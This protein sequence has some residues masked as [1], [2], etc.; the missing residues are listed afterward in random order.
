MD[1]IIEIKGLT[2]YYGSLF[3]K[4]K[5]PSLYDL[6]L[7]IPDGAIFGFLGPNGAGK[8]T[9]IKI[10]MNLIKQSSGEALI[11]GYPPDNVEVKRLIGFLPMLLLSVRI[12]QQPSSL[13]SAPNCSEYRLISAKRE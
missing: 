4:K 12:F 8:T 13:T 9:T 11:L 1:N 10:L 2:K 6:N 5:K 7:T 3:W